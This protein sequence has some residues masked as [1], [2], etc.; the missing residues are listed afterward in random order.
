V[1]VAFDTGLTLRVKEVRWETTPD[2]GVRDAGVEL[3]I[4]SEL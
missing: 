3:E 4:V 2:G 1:V